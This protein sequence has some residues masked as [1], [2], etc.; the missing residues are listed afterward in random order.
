MEEQEEQG[1]RRGEDEAMV[2]AA[3]MEEMVERTREARGLGYITRQL[4]D[5]TVRANCARGNLGT[6]YA[7]LSA[8]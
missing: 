5:A 1:E 7:N 3:A 6:V 2:A 4:P 8:M